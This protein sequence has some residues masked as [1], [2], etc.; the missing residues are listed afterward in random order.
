MGSAF[1][2]MRGGMRCFARDLSGFPAD[3]DRRVLDVIG[4]LLH[5]SLRRCAEGQANEEGQSRFTIFHRTA[6]KGPQIQRFNVR[7]NVQFTIDECAIATV[8][9]LPVTY[10]HE[11]TD[12]FPFPGALRRCVVYRAHPIFQ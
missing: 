6:P 10:K 4:R 3:M 8:A 5:V 12:R 9:G 1:G 7:E 2:C 11:Q